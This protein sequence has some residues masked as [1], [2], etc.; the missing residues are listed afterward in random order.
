[1]SRS[2]QT[3]SNAPNKGT[4]I[5]QTRRGVASYDIPAITR[6]PPPSF[7]TDTQTNLWIACLSDV[8]LEFFRARHIPMMIQYVRAVEQMMRYSDLF[9]E[10][11]D[12]IVSLNMWERFSRLVIRLEKHLSL[13]TDKLI[14]MV[15]QARSEMRMAHQMNRAKEAGRDAANIRAGLIYDGH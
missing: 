5:K 1:M 15:T 2:D 3:G 14:T 4:I 12:D 13:H 8:P 6:Y 9:E 7:L 10:D 11:P